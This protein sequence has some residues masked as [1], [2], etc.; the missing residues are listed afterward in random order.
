MPGQRQAQVT[1]QQGFE[2]YGNLLLKYTTQ[3]EGLD[4]ARRLTAE[5][6]PYHMTSWQ[7][8]IDLVE[9]KPDKVVRQKAIES[10]VLTSKVSKYGGPV[11]VDLS[12]YYIN[13]RLPLV[14]GYPGERGWVV[15]APGAS[16]VRRFGPSGIDDARVALSSQSVP[17]ANTA[18][19][20]WLRRGA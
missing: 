3:E 5:G 9:T 12:L 4:A 7:E 17:Q 19:A 1:Q 2:Q 15:L 16:N 10:V 18:P 20:E 6:R 14:G 8:T 13:G 11:A